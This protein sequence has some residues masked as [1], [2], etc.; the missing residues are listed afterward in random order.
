MLEA[1]RRGLKGGL[2]PPFRIPRWGCWRCGLR[3]SRVKG[4]ARSAA[5]RGVYAGPPFEN[6]P[7]GLL[8]GGLRQS[9]ARFKGGPRSAALR[10]VHAGSPLEN[11]P[12]ACGAPRGDL[13]QEGVWT[14]ASPIV[15]VRDWLW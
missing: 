15:I 4:G 6:P 5:L 12:A 8:A 2:L 14:G 11:P 10:G 7:L 3:D 1:A 9:L 13:Y